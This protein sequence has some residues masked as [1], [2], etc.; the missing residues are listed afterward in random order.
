MNNH[1]YM[2]KIRRNFYIMVESMFVFATIS[3]SGSNIKNFRYISVVHT[4][5]IL[6]EVSSIIFH[7]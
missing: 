7:Y 4:G 3:F 2:S 5:K 1:K 6:I